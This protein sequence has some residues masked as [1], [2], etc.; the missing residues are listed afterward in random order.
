VNNQLGT[1]QGF[2]R[3]IPQ[4]AVSIRYH[5]NSFCKVAH[6]FSKNLQHH[7]CQFRRAVAEKVRR[8][9]PLGVLARI[10]ARPAGRLTV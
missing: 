1:L 5:P 4:Q 10:L 6:D 8:L 7:G 9:F 3:L 2:D